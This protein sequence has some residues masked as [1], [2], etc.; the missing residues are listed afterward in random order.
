MVHASD[1]PEQI[2]D[3]NE[4]KTETKELATRCN[5]VN[6]GNIP[7]SGSLGIKTFSVC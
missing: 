7:S 4:K 1:R 3:Q 6:Q 2:N 5:F